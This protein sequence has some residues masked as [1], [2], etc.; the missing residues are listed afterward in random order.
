MRT[1]FPYKLPA[2]LLSACGDSEQSTALAPAEEDNDP[3]GICRMLSADDA[4]S[5][6]PGNNG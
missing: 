5:V 6:L 4:S 3:F 2:L 1:P